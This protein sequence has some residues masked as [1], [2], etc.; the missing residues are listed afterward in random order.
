MTHRRDGVRTLDDIKGRCWVDPITGCWQ[1]RGAVSKSTKGRKIAPTSRVWVPEA[2]GAS[3]ITTAHR[4][5]WLLAGNTLAP[6]HVVWRSVCHNDE[7]IN[8][9]HCS[10]GTRR[11]MFDQI[12]ES[13]V[14]RGTALRKAVNAR[15]CRVQALPADKVRLGEAMFQAGALQKE[16]RKALGIGVETARKIRRGTHPY[17]SGRDGLSTAPSV[18]NWR[19]A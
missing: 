10:A 17:S 5:A 15:N 4:A 8:P 9:A 18:F 19:P 11:E 14:L 7:C 12:V 2:F 3:K 1:W 13:G 6:G 16:V